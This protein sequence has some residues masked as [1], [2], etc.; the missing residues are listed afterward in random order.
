MFSLLDTA[1]TA[2]CLRAVSDRRSRLKEE[3]NSLLP[4][5]V[6]VGN[7]FVSLTGYQAKGYAI[8]PIY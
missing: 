4:N 7:T 1:Y 2:F 8:I 3:I 6:H 5:V